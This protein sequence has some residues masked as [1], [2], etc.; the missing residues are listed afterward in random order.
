MSTTG[1]RR[2]LALTLVLAMTAL[3][4][5]AAPVSATAPEP[6][7]DSCAAGTYLPEGATSCIQASPGHF[8]A[9]P[10]AV[11][12]Q[13][14]PAGT[15]QPA[16]GASSCLLASAGYFVDAPAATEQQACPDGTGSLAGAVTCTPTASTITV[17]GFNSNVDA[18][19]VLRV[20][21]KQAIPL[22]WAFTDGTSNH[23]L[24]A[25]TVSVTSVAS[26]RC[27]AGGVDGLEPAT[28]EGVT[29]ASGLQLLADG[30]YQVNWKAT[31]T[32]GCR[33][34]TVTAPYAVESGL[35]GNWTRTILVDI[36]K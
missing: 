10:G 19:A 3:T 27:T 11:A 15:Y 25:G 31:S 17:G 26:P 13:A 20:K 2:R 6:G 7:D 36:R 33:A 29:G 12:Q 21:P 23:A 22:Q 5:L 14:C 34:L 16:A 24:L 4:T 8:V 28:S 9:L 18:T 30:S 1:T 32:T 35:S